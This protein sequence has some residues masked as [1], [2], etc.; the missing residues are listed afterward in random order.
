MFTIFTHVK[1]NPRAQ[2]YLFQ[3]HHNSLIIISEEVL[4][5]LAYAVGDLSS[6]G[7]SPDRVHLHSNALSTA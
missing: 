2:K 1:A 7:L 3:K 4:T 5:F 6:K